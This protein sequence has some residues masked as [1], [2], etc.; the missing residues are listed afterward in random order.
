MTWTWMSNNIFEKSTH[1]ISIFITKVYVFI[2]KCD[3]N[4][5]IQIKQFNK[6]EI[7]ETLSY[8]GNPR[9]QDKLGRSVYK[10]ENHFPGNTCVST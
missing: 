5:I 9:E 7:A 6:I 1:H 2:L 10:R 8:Y 3:I 4:K